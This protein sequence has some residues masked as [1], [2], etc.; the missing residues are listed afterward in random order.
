MHWTP[1]SAGRG[2]R[3]RRARGG[4][5]DSNNKFTRNIY[6][7]AEFIYYLHGR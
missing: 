1:N 5:G 3:A 4:G 2:A 7:F 6:K